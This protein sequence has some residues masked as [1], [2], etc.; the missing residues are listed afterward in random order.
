MVP[1]P[2]IVTEHWLAFPKSSQPTEMLFVFKLIVT[3]VE[4]IRKLSLRAPVFPDTVSSP[5]RLSAAPAVILIALSV[6]GPEVVIVDAVVIVTVSF[7]LPPGTPSG[8]Q[9]AAVSQIAVPPP[10]SQVYAVCAHTPPLPIRANRP[11]I[12]IY[13]T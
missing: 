5:P 11:A 3:P 2:V 9:F 10:P 4:S 13:R 6:T 1:V 12:T 7:A 8:F